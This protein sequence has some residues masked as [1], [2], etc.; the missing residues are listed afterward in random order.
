MTSCRRFA[1]LAAVAV[2]LG[3]CGSTSTPRPTDTPTSATTSP[4]SSPTTTESGALG[5]DLLD[6]ASL[7]RGPAPE[8][9][10]AVDPAPVFGDG[11]F[12]LVLDPDRATRQLAPG[13]ISDFIVFD[14]GRVVRTFDTEAGVVV[15]VLDASG[16]VVERAD[17]LS[18]Y[19]LVTTADRSIVGWLDANG[20]PQV[21]EDGATRHLPLPAVE[22]GDHL[23]ALLGSGTCQEQAPEGGGC[24]GFVDAAPD[25]RRPRA[26]LTTSHGIVDTVSH[27]S[28]VRDASADGH[29]VGRVTGSGDGTGCFG[30]LSPRGA[31]RWQTCDH[32]LTDFSP[33]GAHVIGLTGSSSD[34]GARGLT[35]YDGSGAV[36]AGWSF[37]EGRT[38]IGDIAW[39]SDGAV[40]VVLND[41]DQWSVV[42]LLLDGTAE[43]AVAPHDVGPDFSPFR[44]PL[45]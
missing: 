14:N 33:D 4:P 1:S 24:T 18:G 43:Q 26:W 12:N 9:V 31:M 5:T 19:G 11:D 28:D 10:Y 7:P 44:L 27:L 21:L 17:G 40:L 13:P 25:A 37:P 6:V 20:A 34:A 42:R 35:V 32:Q 16:E 15:E 29:L 45:S 23:G 39:E 22:D 30:E 3:G 38:R 2:L 8:I 41:G 36:A